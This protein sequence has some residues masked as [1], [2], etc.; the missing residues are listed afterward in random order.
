MENLS[1]KEMRYMA[2][3][4]NIS[5]YKGMPKDKLLRMINNTSSNNNS[6]NNNKRDRN[7]LFKSKKV[8]II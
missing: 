1:Q 3:N 6:S 4:R 5:G 8:F 2:K 7:S